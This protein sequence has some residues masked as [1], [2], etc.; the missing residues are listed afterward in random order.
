MFHEKKYASQLNI[1]QIFK[2]ALMSLASTM[3]KST[4]NKN[5]ITIR[6]I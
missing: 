6:E 1:W 3:S 4:I 5:S 2:N